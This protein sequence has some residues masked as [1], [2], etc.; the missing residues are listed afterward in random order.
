MK[1]ESGSSFNEIKPIDFPWLVLE[2]G[3]PCCV[4]Q[5]D[6]R[7]LDFLS[8]RRSHTL[9]GSLLLLHCPESYVLKSG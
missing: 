9:L 3:F 7:A 1:E 2:G 4:G 6:L 8:L 5:L